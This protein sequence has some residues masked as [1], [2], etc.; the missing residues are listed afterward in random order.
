MYIALETKTLM[1]SITETKTPIPCYGAKVPMY[2][3]MEIKALV[4]I[5]VY[6][7]SQ[8]AHCYRN[9]SVD[10]HSYRKEQSVHIYTKLRCTLFWKPKHRCTL[11]CKANP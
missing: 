8:H 7:R 3:A 5:V 9:Q 2:T 6:Q 4:Y 10:V 1:D 11:L